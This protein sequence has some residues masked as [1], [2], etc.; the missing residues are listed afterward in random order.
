MKQNGS[1]SG[2]ASCKELLVMRRR[3]AVAAALSLGLA[4][5]ASHADPS[6]IARAAMFPSGS[7]E[8]QTQFRPDTAEI[9][10]SISLH[11]VAPGDKVTATWIAEKANGVPLNY[12]ID[13]STVAV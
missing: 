1:V 4:S 7:S 5:G 13:S 6:H 8:P 12:K 3:F 11:D 10:V 9:R 2:P